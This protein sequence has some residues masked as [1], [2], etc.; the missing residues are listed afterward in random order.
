[1][2]FAGT[3][4]MATLTHRTTDISSTMADACADPTYED[5]DPSF[6]SWRAGKR[7]WYIIFLLATISVC[8]VHAF[9][10]LW[11][12]LSGPALDF[13]S[14]RQTQTAISAYW[15][16]RDGFRLAYETPVFGFPWSIPFEFPIYQWLMVLARYAGVPFDIGGRLISFAFYIASLLPLWSLTKSFKLGRPI[17][18][19]I[20]ILFLSS[21]L[22]V[23]YSRTIMIESCALFFGLAWL[24]TLA[25]FLEKP[26]YSTLMGAIVLGSLAALAKSTTFPPF[27]M[28]GGL[29]ILSGLSA[30]WRDTHSTPSFGTLVL[31]GAACIAP[32]CVGYAWVIYSDAIK[33]HNVVGAMLTSTN[34][35]RWNF[36]TWAQRFG[37][38][39]WRDVI[40]T[41]VLQD[42]FGYGVAVALA[43]VSAI[44]TTRRHLLIGLA[45]I[46]AFLVPFLLF[47]NLYIVHGYYPYANAIFALAAVGLAIGHIAETGRLVLAGLILAAILLGQL[48]YFHATYAPVID[49][50]LSLSHINQ[51]AQLAKHN[52]TPDDGLIVLG[53]DWSSAVP[54]YSERKALVIPKWVPLPIF[55]QMLTKPQ[56]FLDNLHLG[57]IVYCTDYGYGDRAPLI[58][59]FVLRRSV[60]AEAGACKLLS[61]EQQ[62]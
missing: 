17:F 10:Y 27:V 36:G 39:L 3:P 19:V 54:Y 31:A 49:A 14:F 15:A 55:E 26:N 12:G 37:A 6:D 8:C 45:V 5:K 28:I 51:I 16:W 34:L 43:V 21:P 53:Q 58:D 32:L 29:L 20:A 22:Y 40:F 30:I 56:M 24:A 4:D 25:R 35:A 33:T 41:R 44:L 46:A 18:L 11:I 48:I 13:Y 59:A 60:I 1:M 38:E 61:P 57:A 50:D 62:P 9:Y 52:T 7:Y 23:Y 2:N 42:T 47:T